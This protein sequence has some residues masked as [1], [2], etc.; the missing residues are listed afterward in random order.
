MTIIEKVDKRLNDTFT[1]NLR[2]FL[3]EKFP[4]VKFESDFNICSMRMTTTWDTED[5]E[6]C[7]EIKKLAEA[8][9]AAYSKARREI[10]NA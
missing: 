3:G 5:P 1:E 7:G 10:W 2:G 9:E 6:K 8:Y 4:D